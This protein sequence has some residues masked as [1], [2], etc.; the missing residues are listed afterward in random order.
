[1]PVTTIEALLHRARKALKRE[2]MTVSSGRGLAGV[3]VFGWLV[4]RMA[5]LRA[6]VSGRTVGQL[7]P[8]A[9]SAAAGVAAIGLVLNPLGP[10]PSL[11]T[12]SRP[13][14]AVALAYSSTPAPSTISIAVPATSASVPSQDRPRASTPPAPPPAPSAPVAA[15]GP[16]GVFSGKQGTEDAQH[17]NDQQPVQVDLAVI[18]AGLNPIQTINDA[19]NH[20]PGGTP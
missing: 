20:L 9:G 13:P 19:A 8:I 18:E 1:V 11:P 3:P 10:A 4:F 6:K 16:V 17:A 5:R 12:L 15:A 14:A 2:F 7:A